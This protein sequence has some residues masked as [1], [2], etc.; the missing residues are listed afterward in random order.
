MYFAIQDWM[1][2]NGESMF[3]YFKVVMLLL[4]GLWFVD[5]GTYLFAVRMNLLY[6]YTELLIVS[7]LSLTMNLL[8]VLCSMCTVSLT[9]ILLSLTMYDIMCD[10]IMCT[11][12]SVS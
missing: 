7:A 5:L 2:R 1:L 12:I 11:C 9:H 6:Q 3:I 10:F 4:Y 8:K